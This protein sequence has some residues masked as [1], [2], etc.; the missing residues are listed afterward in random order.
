MPLGG[1]GG[2]ATDHVRRARTAENGATAL[3]AASSGAPPALEASPWEK[4][5]TAP[6]RGPAAHLTPCSQNQWFFCFF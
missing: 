1:K 6:A 3:R 4:V 2:D 5:S